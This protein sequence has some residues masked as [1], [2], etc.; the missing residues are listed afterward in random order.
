MLRLL[1]PPLALLLPAGLAQ[2][3]NAQCADHLTMQQHLAENWGESRQ[4][5]ALDAANSVVELY[6]SSETGT[7]SLLVTTPGG[8]TCMIASGNAFEMVN[9][10]LPALGE[11]A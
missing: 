8:P 1:I 2:A 6:A 9:E 4:S 10:P 5:I 7:W 3:Q 11:G